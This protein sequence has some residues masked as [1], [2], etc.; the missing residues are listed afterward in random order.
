[1]RKANTSRQWYWYQVRLWAST[2]RCL[3]PLLRMTNSIQNTASSKGF[4]GLSWW[5]LDKRIA[6]SLYLRRW[7]QILLYVCV[8]CVQSN[9]EQR[10]I[11]ISGLKSRVLLCTDT[12]VNLIWMTYEELLMIVLRPFTRSCGSMV[13]MLSILTAAP[14]AFIW[15]KLSGWSPNKG[16]P[17]IGTP[18]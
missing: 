7:R 17:T 8:C 4:T 6:F 15:T 1:M 3:A 13:L 10:A 9:W 12:T 14:L 2:R 5:I 11:K 18:W 16:I